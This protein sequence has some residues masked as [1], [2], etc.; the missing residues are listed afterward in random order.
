MVFIMLKN[1]F[2][3]STAGI[4]FVGVCIGIG[5]LFLQFSGNP[6]NMGICVVCFERD[7]AGAL[8]FHRAAI[9]QYL[10]PEI[11][12]LVL[13]SFLAA[14]LFGEF[15]SRGG[16][17]PLVRFFLGVIAAVS[18]L[19]FL[20]CPWRAVL[21]LAGGDL[22]ALVGLLGL[23]SGIFIGVQFFKRG[24]SLGKSSEQSSFTGYVFPILM[25]CLLILY[26][27]FPQIQGEV[28]NGVLFYSDKG[29]GS[30]HAPVLISLGIALAIGFL[31]QRSRFCTMGAFRDVFLFRYSHLFLGIFALFVTVLIGNFLMGT[32]KL[33]FEGQPIAHAD[34]LW[35]FLSML[36][37][38]FAFSLAGACPGRQLFLG[39]EGDSDAAVFAIGVLVG[40]AIAH[41]MMTASSAV[42]IG[43]YGAWATII[44]IVLCFVIAFTHIKK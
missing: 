1:N 5:A 40:A 28:S 20:G 9:V 13:G 22:N 26:F 16:S 11:I 27:M 43:T 35:N 33:G 44:C 30:M 2:F 34:G 19:V 7:T 42:A 17:S 29:P 18:A 14:K 10:R 8:G 3:A 24:Y 15:K 21:R 37:A 23:A 38:G 41:N 36:S 6:G 39:G 4:I 31:A 32:F 25:V 12:G